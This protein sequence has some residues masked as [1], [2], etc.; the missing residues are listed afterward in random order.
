MIIKKSQLENCKKT[1]FT[2]KYKYLLNFTLIKTI[3]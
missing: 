1:K 3:V 2:F